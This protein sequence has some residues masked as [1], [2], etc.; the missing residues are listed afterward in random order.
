MISINRRQLDFVFGRQYWAIRDEGQNI[1]CCLRT[2]FSAVRDFDGLWIPLSFC[3][4]KY[5]N[6][7]SF[8][9]FCNVFVIILSIATVNIWCINIQICNNGNCKSTIFVEENVISS[10]N[11]LRKSILRYESQTY[12]NQHHHYL[13]NFWFWT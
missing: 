10:F 8:F 3:L 6:Q 5:S 9:Y 13:L 2:S 12:G 4:L 11:I 7:N 1:F